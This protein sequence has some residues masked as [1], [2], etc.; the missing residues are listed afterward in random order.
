MRFSSFT[1]YATPYLVTP[2]HT[3]DTFEA[4]YVVS[5][6]GH[7]RFLA[8]RYPLRPGDFFLVPPGKP[9]WVSSSKTGILTQIFFTFHTEAREVAL[10]EDLKTRFGSGPILS[11]GN[12]RTYYFETLRKNAESP[13]PIRNRWATS[14]WTQFLYDLILRG[15][16]DDKNGS[17]PEEAIVGELLRVMYANL[18]TGFSVKAEARRLEKSEAWLN[19]CFRRAL[20]VPPLRHYLRLKID[21][22]SEMLLSDGTTV[23]QT[24]EAFGFPDVF[25]FSKLFKKFRGHPPIEFVRRRGK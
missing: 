7:F 24:A 21:A 15:K 22:A 23:T 11:I 25:Y 6:S 19:R 4:H 17:G 3:H 16:E 12:H 13:E 5:G 9:H 18:R 2:L 8:K 20:G 10:F 14:S 1:T